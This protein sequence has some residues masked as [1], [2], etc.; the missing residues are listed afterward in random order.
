MKNVRRIKT[1]L[2]LKII[3]IGITV[4]LVTTSVAFMKVMVNNG[5]LNGSESTP[6]KPTFQ[7]RPC[8]VKSVLT[9]AGTWISFDSSSPGTPA[10]AHV[11]ISDTSGITIVA[12]FHGFWRDNH[13]INGTVYDDPKIPGASSINE[14]GK[15]MLPCLFEYVQIPYG[16]DVSI[17]VLSSTSTNISG[18]N[19]RPAPPPYIPFT[20][21]ETDLGPLPYTAPTTYLDP[22]YS[23]NTLFPRDTTST[24]GESNSTSMIM[25]GHRLLGLNFYPIQFN[26]VTSDLKVYSQLVLK[27]KYS[28]PAQIEPVADHLYSEP[29]ERIIER[30]VLNCYSSNSVAIVPRVGVDPWSRIPNL[31]F[32][33][34]EYLII[35]TANFEEHAQRLVEWKE[36]KGIPSAVRVVAE[37][38]RQSVKDFLNFAYYKWFPAPTYVLL[39]GDVEFIPANYDV[40]HKAITPTGIQYYED[41][42]P[43][44]GNIASD[45]GYFNIE[46]NGYFPDMIYGRISVDTEMQAEIIVNK[47]L[48]YEQSPPANTTFYESFLSAG[49]F[50]DMDSYTNSRDG[51]EDIGY[52]HIYTLERIRHYLD[53]TLGYNSHI[54]YSCRGQVAAGGCIPSE[55]QQ[56]VIPSDS[57][58][59]WVANVLP[60]D[61]VWLQGYDWSGT[62]GRDYYYDLEKNAVTPNFNQGRFLVLYYG[63]GGSKNMYNPFDTLPGYG[64]MEYRD[65]TEGWHHPCLNTSHFADLTNGNLTPLVL[66]IA[67]NTGWFDGETDQDYLNRDRDSQNAFDECANE[68]FAENITRLPGGGAIAAIASSRHAYS[69]ISA[70][71]LN[72][73][74][75]ALWPGF[76]GSRN[77]PIYEMGGALLFSKIYAVSEYRS[78]VYNERRTTFEE[79]HLFGD[80]ETQ[81]WTDVPL[82]LTVEYPDQI[83]IGNQ[84]FVVT[85]THNYTGFVSNAKVCLQK[86]SDI[87]QVGYTD[88]RGQVIFNVHPSYPGMM[89]LT[90]TKHNY[91]PHMGE[92]ECVC[93]GATL[94]LTPEE[95]PLGSWV[96]LD[97]HGF[98]DTEDV[99]IYY[100]S[101][102]EVTLAAG[103]TRSNPAPSG[104]IGF[105]NIIARGVDSNLVAITVYRRY[106]ANP[107]PD[108]Y[109]YSRW[110]QSTWDMLGVSGN[111][112]G[113]Y[114]PDIA[115]YIGST[116]VTLA[117]SVYQ[118]VTY[119]VS[120]NVHNQGDTS[121]SQTKVTLKYAPIG[122][123][124][125]WT[126]SG[127]DTI[128]TISS[129]GSAYANI[130]WQ[131]PSDGEYCL[132]AIIDNSNDKNLDNNVGV[133]AVKVIEY[134]SPGVTDFMVGNPTDSDHY[135]F[136]NVKQQGNHSNVWNST[137]MGYSSQVINST[138]NETI[139]IQIDPRLDLEEN[140]WRLFVAE[141]YVKCQLVGGVSFNVSKAQ[142]SLPDNFIDPT[143]LAVIVGIGG[144]LGIIV[145]YLV[146][147]RKN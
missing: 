59:K 145:L 2:Y 131:P 72:G 123:G 11:T 96:T 13:T 107:R 100:E 133:L 82:G 147:K 98:Y 141:I 106:S 102:Y 5:S 1:E 37:D 84:Q 58:T 69:E 28:F 124:V 91:I 144:T 112:I 55:F 139:S 121:A 10:E 66:S 57:S 12:D 137:I 140:E 38:D 113:W 36:R 54:N 65:I 126:Y 63:H 105:V 92:L 35:T 127:E 86:G 135:V 45:L 93:S 68:C 130:P 146:K 116:P 81:L 46:G 101:L 88:P 129:D 99:E 67:C 114:N 53:D 29:F 104:Q 3:A 78:E 14:Y 134:S 49:Y 138:C 27:M 47:T 125:S 122:G 94:T 87:Y 20:V 32:K 132:M 75:Q 115:L 16:V 128:P 17:E 50:E 142:P 15:P 120:I 44:N 48:Q 9:Q 22:V 70:H 61:F 33:G 95:G 19:I 30:N 56:P 119:F 6:E 109:I 51:I 79:Y 25:R 40:D 23:N 26:P 118:T 24:E 41:I 60:D 77:Q 111:D 117:G 52:P 89:N 143:L 43:E 62:W 73:L 97:V 74:I 103:A 7:K 34:A 42:D 71:L 39:L 83:G 76:L 136:I 18:Y 85:V 4:M 90:V 108:P 8:D 80:P 31:F 110:D 21:G 64:G